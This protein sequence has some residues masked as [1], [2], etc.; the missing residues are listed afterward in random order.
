MKNHLYRIRCEYLQDAEGNTPNQDA[1]IFDAEL[2]ED[3]FAIIERL[4]NQGNIASDNAAAFGMGLKLFAEVVLRHK[5]ES[6]YSEILPH[7][8]EIMKEVKGK[9]S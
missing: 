2:H 3:L 7:L 1:L 8:S 5:N 6:P 4:Q 9:K